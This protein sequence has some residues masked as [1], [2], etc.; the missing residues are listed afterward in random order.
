[1]RKLE[2]HKIL[3]Y[4]VV[5][6]TFLSYISLALLFYK[7]VWWS[8][9]MIYVDEIRNEEEDLSLDQWTNLKV[10]D[11]ELQTLEGYTSLKSDTWYLS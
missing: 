9:V 5:S 3:M 8:N 1:M 6:H 2:I 10:T 11:K 4:L 7:Y